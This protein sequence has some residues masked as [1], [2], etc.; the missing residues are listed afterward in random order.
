MCCCP[1]VDAQLCV[2]DAILLSRVKN[3]SVIQK[4]VLSAWLP[5]GIG[6][7]ELCESDKCELCESMPSS[8]LDLLS[9]LRA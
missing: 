7:C 4:Q 6:K 3:S 5:W 9:S 1:M 2:E 8:P